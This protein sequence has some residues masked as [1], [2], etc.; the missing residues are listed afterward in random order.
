MSDSIKKYHELVEDGIIDPNVSYEQ[1]REN[2]I[3]ELL[4]R[5]AKAE[6]LGEVE[7]RA[8][9]VQKEFGSTS[10]LLG[11]QIAVDELLSDER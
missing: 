6:K 2:Q 7:K 8:F 4:A 9:E 11:L 5:A 10:L 1:K 3:L